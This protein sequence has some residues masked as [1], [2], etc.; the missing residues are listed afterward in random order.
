MILNFEITIYFSTEDYMFRPL[1]FA[2]N[3]SSGFESRVRLLSDAF[4]S[5]LSEGEKSFMKMQI[6]LTTVAV[7]ILGG[8]L[9]YADDKDLQNSKDKSQS[10]QSSAQGQQQEQSS[11][12]SDAASAEK[13]SGQTIMFNELPQP[14]QK[15]MRANAGEANLENIQKQNIKGQTCYQ[16]SFDKDN[17]KG[18]LTVAQDGSLLQFQQAEDLAVVAAIP[19]VSTS[20]TKISDLPDAVQKTIKDQAGTD[21]VGNIFKT[22]QNGQTVY[23]AGFNEAGAHTDLFVDENGKLLGKTQET[24][25]FIAPLE[26][27]EKLSL[28]SA[29]EAVQKT[30]REKAGSA[31]VADIDKGKWN[32]QTA[33]KVMVDKNGTPTA[34][35]ISENGNIL[36]QEMSEAAGAENKAK[37]DQD[38]RQDKNS[39]DNQKSNDQ[40]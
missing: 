17:M 34:L 28:S 9:V 2:V 5:S 3:A 13:S 7:G 23:H 32:G 29:P 39:Q 21:Q 36:G 37:Q 38:K 10:S 31:H 14:V 8:R 35:L 18:K 15:T 27:S 4:H 33:Y 22:S 11:V 1:K 16:A 26:S 6:Y 24:A 12:Q 25:L 20:G 40:K 30:V 19:Q